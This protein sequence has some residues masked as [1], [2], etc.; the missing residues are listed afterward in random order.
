MKKH[1]RRMVDMGGSGRARPSWEHPGS[2]E[3][4][5]ND[6]GDNVG[7]GCQRNDDG[8]L[9]DYGYDDAEYESGSNDKGNIDD[10]GDGKVDD[11]NALKHK[12]SESTALQHQAMSPLYF[13]RMTM[14]MLEAEDRW[15][16]AE[17]RC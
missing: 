6:G 8:H 13:M 2:N 9:D 16:E 5:E 11:G 4:E 1:S 7:G 10:D 14:C 3:E 15:S 12:A 17:N